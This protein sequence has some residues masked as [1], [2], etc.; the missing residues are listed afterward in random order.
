M[1]EWKVHYLA[2]R[3]VESLVVSLAGN[4]AEKLVLH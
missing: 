2:D 4:W 1:V 3:L